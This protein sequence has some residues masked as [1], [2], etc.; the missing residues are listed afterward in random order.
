MNSTRLILTLG[1]KS[2]RIPQKETPT[3]IPRIKGNNYKDYILE[4]IIPL[5][6]WSSKLKLWMRVSVMSVQPSSV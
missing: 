1:T 5:G 6:Y 3:K 4:G 2:K